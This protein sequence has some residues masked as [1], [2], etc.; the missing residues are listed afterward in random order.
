MEPV[1][2]INA[3]RSHKLDEHKE[4]LTKGKKYKIEF[5]DCCIEGFVYGTFIEWDEDRQYAKF[6]IGEIGPDWGAWTPKEVKEG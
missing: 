3:K 6:D 1:F 2:N 4:K 5:S